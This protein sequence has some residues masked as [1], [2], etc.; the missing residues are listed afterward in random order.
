MG[1]IVA[2]LFALTLVAGCGGGADDAGEPAPS[3][4]TS[5]APEPRDHTLEQLEAALP[6]VGDVAGG[7]EAA[8]T[9]PADGVDR[10]GESQEQETSIV[11]SVGGATAVDAEMAGEAANYV[12]V[13]AVR[14]A[15][16]EDAEAQLSRL[17]A[18]ADER[19]GSF[20][21]APSEA[22]GVPIPGEK[23]TGTVDDLTT[24]AWTGHAADQDVVPEEDGAR[25]AM[26]N[27]ERA[28]VSGNVLVTVTVF[29]TAGGRADDFASSLADDQL[30]AFL[31]RLG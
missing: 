7:T 25:V 21:I 12:A 2:A 14:Y 26:Q 22:Q 3:A 4:T 17:R 27:A 8:L 13:R 15:T 23:G 11:I 1:R 29:V 9:C 19:K 20:D 31:E 6:A 10:C 24:G 28:V 5:A 18:A 16:A 30:Q